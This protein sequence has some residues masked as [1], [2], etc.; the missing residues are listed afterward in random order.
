MEQYTLC[1]A[2]VEAFKN[3]TPI[4]EIACLKGACPSRELLTVVCPGGFWGY[5]HGLGIPLS[6]KAS[7]EV[8]PEI[9]YSGETLH[10]LVSYSEDFD[11]WQDHLNKIRQ[12]WPKPQWDYANSREKT[13]HFLSTTSPRLVYFYCHGGLT[14]SGLPSL[15]IG[16]SENDLGIVP[17]N[18]PLLINSKWY[19]TR[20]LVFLNGCHTTA[21][22]PEYAMEFVSPFI[23]SAAAGVIGSEITVFEPLACLFAEECFRH[24]LN[25]AAGRG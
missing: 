25:G 22:E 21:L 14:S 17:D 15:H 3:Q 16:S 7:L 20:P 18:L 1:P 23:E 9:T 10:W 13:L 4:E 5:R 8:P 11:R 12:L 19:E 2:F 6:V 24:F